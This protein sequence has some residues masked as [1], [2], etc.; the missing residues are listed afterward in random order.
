[1]HHTHWPDA[2]KHEWYSMFSLLLS[3]VCIKLQ[4]SQHL[5]LRSHQGQVQRERSRLLD[6]SAG[7][8]L[9]SSLYSKPFLCLFRQGRWFK[10]K[11]KKSSR[12]G[13]AK[14]PCWATPGILTWISQMCK[15]EKA[16]RKKPGLKKTTLWHSVATV[17]NITLQRACA[18]DSI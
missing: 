18:P 16:G 17:G 14:N 15:E 6:E 13:K 12:S 11:K 2:I 8:L 9:L 1:M 10:K 7:G 4:Q 3:Q 5:I